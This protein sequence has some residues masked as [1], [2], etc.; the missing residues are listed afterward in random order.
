MSKKRLADRGALMGGL[1]IKRND[2]DELDVIVPVSALHRALDSSRC[3]EDF[4]ELALKD[5][6]L[7][8][9]LALVRSMCEKRK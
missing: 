9:K 6:R 4:E 5:F 1:K 8:A 2:A 3:G 7:L